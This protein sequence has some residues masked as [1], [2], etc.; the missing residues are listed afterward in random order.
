[1]RNGYESITTLQKEEEPH[2]P[3]TFKAT[4]QKMAA[5]LLM[6][7]FLCLE[8]CIS[9]ASSVE[10]A[11]VK[12]APLTSRSG[13]INGMVRVYLS[14]L[15][16]PSTLHL[17][18]RG[19]Y[20]LGGQFL[21]GGTQI[22][23]GFNVSTGNITL[24]YN[25]TTVNAGKQ[26]ALRRHSAGGSN[27]IL[28]SESRDSQNPYPGDLSFEAVASGGGYRLYTIAHVYIENYLYGV[29]PYEMG[30]SSSV[31]ALKAQAVAART[32]TV[33]MMRQRASGRYDVQDTTSDQVYRGTPS[34][35]AN[36]VTA[37]D[38]TR[39]IVLME[40]GSYITT[41]YSASNGGQTET[42]RTG[43]KHAYMRV[44]DDPFDYANP[45]STVKRKTIDANLG[46][47][48]NPSQLIS[49]L[50]EKAVSKLRAQGYSSTLA[51]TTL[52][53]LKS[54]TPHT[55]KY[56]SP[57]R[58]YTKMD[59]TFTVSTQNASG[60]SVT[61]S[62]TV[63]C[64]I[65][66]E[67]EDRLSMGIQSLDN[68]L[69][70]V[71][72]K[73]GSFVLE[74]R[75]YGHGMGMSQRGAMYMGKL[76][77]TYDQILGFYYEGCQ[78]VQHSFTNTILSASSTDLET[79]VEPP[80]DLETEDS[81]ACRATV[82]LAQSGA[83]LAVRAQASSTAAVIGSVSNGAMVSVLSESNGWCMIRFG[84]ICGYVPQ[85]ALSISGTPPQQEAQPSQTL[86]FVSVTANDFVN[87]R[88]QPSM[89]GK[90]L[91]TAPTGAVLTVFS[92][93]S[94]W[95]R[96]QYN[97]LAAYVNLGYV[98]A[99]SQTPPTQ[100]SSGTSAARLTQPCALLQTPST[101]AEVL[102]ELAQDTVVTVL[103]SDGSWARVRAQEQTGYV[104][105]ELLADTDAQ[106][107]SGNIPDDTPDE[108]TPGLTAVV[109]TETGSLNLRAEARAG[110]RVLTT[111]P[112]GATVDVL[113]RGGDWCGV[114]YAGVTGYAM[115]EFLTF[116]GDE[117]QQP[118]APVQGETTATVVTPSGSL[119]L[120]Q[121]PRTGSRILTRVPPY[122]V[123]QVHESGMEWCFVTYAGYTGYV[124]TSFLRFEEPIVTPTPEPGESTETVTPE[125]SNTVTP[126][127]E[128]TETVTPSPEPTETATPSPEPTP[129]PEPAQ[130]PDTAYVHTASGSLNLR[131]QPSTDSRI[132]RA[133]PRGKEVT[134]LAYGEPWCEVRYLGAEGYVMTSFLRFEAGDADTSQPQ[135]STGS[136]EPERQE[137]TALVNTASGSLNL[138]QA[139]LKD[140]RILAQMPRLA[141]VTVLERGSEWSRVRYQGI[142]GFAMTCFLS[143]ADAPQTAPSEHEPPRRD[144]QPEE[145]DPPQPDVKPSEPE[146]SQPD[147]TEE[148]PIVS[149]GGVKLDITLEIPD[150]TLFAR[151][152]LDGALRLW[153][154]CEKTGDAIGN[155]PTGETVEV[156]LRGQ[157]WCRVDYDGMQGYC[158]TSE[159]DGV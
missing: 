88:S 134:I 91:G 53:T 124:M 141:Q 157:T 93:E 42:S 130:N 15:G 9:F 11:Q 41:Y 103:S 95:A 25:G 66:G 44:K 112:R 94:G 106:P 122:E 51:N 151:N 144:P 113:Q 50:K 121:L 100:L 140:A 71:Q 57:S 45:S 118:N 97:A 40:N 30:N 8:P 108:P 123:V 22:T 86:G 35:N 139:P 137:E 89:S 21:S 102:A 145:P 68:E 138:R 120:R 109:T 79:T 4:V 150:G 80:A 126:G 14:S 56:A 58:L 159:L 74:A 38:A 70:S 155:V 12:S 92:K 114:S 146:P 87:L 129:T 143:V 136:G 149:S 63:T 55:P 67:L 64:D 61:T 16:S 32:Y 154:M 96:V 128:S 116:A 54:V 72:K 105:A 101:A 131:Q 23:L 90:I 36:C 20:S 99:I 31:E 46:S 153:P 13:A 49:L 142:E 85:N 135:P 27:G 117:Q 110:S 19:N 28:I 52:Q 18:V 78:R 48:S 37:V 26:A 107:D 119:N 29:L 148:E 69:W 24:S 75:R 76:G 84:E 65:F 132:L 152:A 7:L 10:S 59:F 39:G 133:I 111:I 81:S 6:A 156:I 83:S 127:P 125:P 3:C 1:M 104:L 147:E 158:L 62:Q 2:L 47:A 33:R 5:I 115:S 43:A 77:Y 82:T 17:T 60:Q 34:G 73:S 98:S